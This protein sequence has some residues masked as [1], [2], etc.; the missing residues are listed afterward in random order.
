MIGGLDLALTYHRSTPF[1]DAM[2][3]RWNEFANVFSPAL[4]H[5]WHTIEQT[6]ERQSGPRA[7]AVWPV[8]P[9]EL[10][11]GKSLSAKMWCALLPPAKSALVVVR[12]RELAQEFADDVNQW[13]GH[14]VALYSP[15]GGLP[16][17]LWTSPA[18]TLSTPTVV[19]CHKSYE[20]G[21]DELSPARSLERFETVHRFE[22]HPRDLVIIDEALDQVLESR[23]LRDD[24]S[25]LLTF[26]RQHR[27]RVPVEALR[28]LRSIDEALFEA[29]DANRAIAVGT[30]LAGVPYLS[31]IHI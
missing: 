22:G 9:A 31:L 7:T 26:V 5:T 20:M 23:L 21:L 16:N 15:R 10:G 25:K 1:L 2:R 11:S 28:V 8:I 29:P 19:I 27:L 14:A 6:F 24:V 4:V 18:R 17:D 13:G 12:T 30:L 3:A